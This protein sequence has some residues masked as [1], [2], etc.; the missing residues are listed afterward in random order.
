MLSASFLEFIKA[1]NLFEKNEHLLL[2]ISGGLDSVVLA[3]LLSQNN[4]VF[5]MAHMNFQ[6]RGEDSNK[7][8]EFVKELANQLDVRI[9]VKRVGIDKNAGSTQIQARELRYAWFDELIEKKSF[10]KLLTAHH[11]NDLLE[12]ALLNLSRGTGIKGLRS[13]LPLQNGIARPLLFA[14][15]SVLKQFAQ[16]NSIEWREDISNASDHYTRNKIRQHVIPKMLE[17]N[18][19][20]VSGFQ[21]TAWR[22]RATEEAWNDKLQEISKDYFQFK[23]KDV[24]IDKAL[25][26]KPHARVYLSELLHD[27]GFTLS[28]LQSFDF[29]RTGAQL[30]SS[31]NILSI[32]RN[33]ILITE[34]RN[35]DILKFFP[36]QIEVK[37]NPIT[38]P[39]GSLNFEFIKKKE[40]KFDNNQN[41]AFI[42]Y[43]SLKE[44]LEIDQWQEGD[45]IQPIGM[46]GKK[47]ISDILID[48]KIPLPQKKRVMILK[49]GGE[50]VWVIGHKFSNSF[51]VKADTKEIIRIRYENS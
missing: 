28:Q 13:I 39:L 36:L 40:L 24:E 8:E 22:L 37:E 20:L 11:A 19:N 32:D 3:H 1:E 18:P 38:T 34:I 43:E 4:F 35:E 16:E 45:K 47:K 41:V 12:T 30:L 33:K 10:D 9:Y 31:S 21:Q 29:N 17:L 6:L 25:M 46:K 27:F 5:S 49:S 48:Q 42:D 26:K 15:K 2:A 7:D 50:I 14:E 23:N 44:P 51:K